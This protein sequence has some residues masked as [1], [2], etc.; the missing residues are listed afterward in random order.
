MV[1]RTI[2]IVVARSLFSRFFFSRSVADL[3]KAGSALIQFGRD[4]IK[5]VVVFLLT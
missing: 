5:R 3:A 4:Y 2:V 1:Q